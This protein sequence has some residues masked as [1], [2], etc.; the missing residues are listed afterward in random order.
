M[1]TI[2][3]NGFPFTLQCRLFDFIALVLSSVANGVDGF[4]DQLAA[5]LCQDVD[6][7]HTVVLWKGGWAYQGVG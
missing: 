1:L 6:G 7:V 3:L 4:R 5:D 2:R